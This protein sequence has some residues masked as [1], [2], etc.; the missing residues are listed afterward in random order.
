MVYFSALQDYL[1]NSKLSVLFG[2][3]L[4]FVFF[5]LFFS[6]IIVGSGSIFLEY[7]LNN[8][9]LV[10]FAIEI[11]TIAVFLVFYAVFV[12]FIIFNVRNK[13]SNVRM[14]YYLKDKLH[15]FSLK[16]F[17]FFVFYV[18][19]LFFTATALISAGVSVYAVNLLLLL[20]SL[21]LLFVPQSIVIDEAPMVHSIQNNFEFIAKN[22]KNFL[23]AV[24]A[25]I[26]L[27]ALIP[28]IEMAFD[29]V[30]FSGRFVSIIILLVL[31][32][33]YIEVLKTRLY[34]S[35]FGLALSQSRY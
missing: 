12:S 34:M 10:N 1:E 33:P 19:L 15:K 9:N 8:I 20:I 17:F 4:V 14:E 24:I 29:F 32:V 6:N 35:K 18:F 3:L 25:S 16:L 22:P 7:N 11:I 28:L 2:V 27:L 23:R 30:A 13:L 21:A 5:F 31:I 26:I